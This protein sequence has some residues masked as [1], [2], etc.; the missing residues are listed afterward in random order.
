MDC[1][2]AG[3]VPAPLATKVLCLAVGATGCASD[4]G[5]NRRTLRETVIE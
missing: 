3:I 5:A 1:V 2:G 4:A